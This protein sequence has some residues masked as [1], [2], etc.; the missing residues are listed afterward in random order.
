M[1]SAESSSAMYTV[2]LQ[3]KHLSAGAEPHFEAAA[4]AGADGADGAAGAGAGAEREGPVQDD[5]RPFGR[6]P[7]GGT[8]R[9]TVGCPMMGAGVVL[10]WAGAAGS[11]W[12][13]DC[14]LPP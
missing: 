5:G 7:G 2:L 10:A 14:E 13:R 8:A 3:T 9:S 12:F 4:G 1:L 11:S 6:L